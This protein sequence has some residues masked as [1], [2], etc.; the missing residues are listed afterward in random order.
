MSREDRAT[1]HVKLALSYGVAAMVAMAMLVTDAN[2]QAA[3][4]EELPQQT[5][6]LAPSGLRNSSSTT[7]VLVGCV[8]NSLC[9]L[10][11]YFM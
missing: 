8:T 9:Y 1:S 2:A 11:R 5:R 4:E 3:A 7:F 6:Q 10:L